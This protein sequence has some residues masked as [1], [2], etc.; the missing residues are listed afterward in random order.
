MSE[1]KTVQTLMD[2]SGRR[3]LVTGATGHLGR[4]IAE[5]L[6]ELGANLILLDR[7]QSA[8]S[9]LTNEMTGQWGVQVNNIACDLE[10]D[11]QRNL[12]IEGVISQY[13]DLNILINNAAFVGDSSL[14]GWNVPFKDQSLSTWR[15]AIE[16]NLTAAFHLSQAL[17]P[18]LM[19]SQNASIINIA[20]IYGQYGPDWSL[21]EGS[22]MYNPAAYAVSKG[23]LLQFS[24]WLATTAAP[25]VRVNSVSPGGI[26][27]KQPEI[28]IE[29]YA[30]KT[31]LGRMA[32]EDDFKG[33]IAYLASD[34]SS[35]VTGQNITIDGGWGV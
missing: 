21:Y 9:S 19:T 11:A 22:D 15:R 27:R 20:S 30:R 2:L 5:T 34:L 4:T 28:F 31:P 14:D 1:K 25:L 17:L 35:Y 32:C 7:N 24:R 10:D 26:L 3:A 23:G 18:L 16:V 6:A 12:A 13:S 29:R 8:L 33:V